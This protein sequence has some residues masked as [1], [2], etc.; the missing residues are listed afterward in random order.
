MSKV[1]S[2]YF[3]EYSDKNYNL[4][5]YNFFQLDNYERYGFISLE[6]ASGDFQRS[7]CTYIAFDIQKRFYT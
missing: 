2:R 1:R 6:F 7:F 5:C 4:I 3:F